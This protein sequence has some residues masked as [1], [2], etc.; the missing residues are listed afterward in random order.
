MRQARGSD[1]P[2]SRIFE[3]LF[4]RTIEAGQGCE[5]YRMENLE[6]QTVASGDD[7]GVVKVRCAL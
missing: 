3:T 2:E 7:D 5:I 1:S 4:D 6:G